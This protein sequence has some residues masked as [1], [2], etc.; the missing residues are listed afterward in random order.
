MARGPGGHHPT[1]TKPGLALLTAA[2]TTVVMLLVVG[3][4]W[5]AFK[6][7]DGLGRTELHEECRTDP[8]LS[9]LQGYCVVVSRHP[10]TPAH[11]ERTYL[12]ITQVWDG[13]EV[14]V[15]FRAQYP[16]HVGDAGT[17]LD[18]DWSRPDE[19][20]VVADPETGSAISY[21]FDQYGSIR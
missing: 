4:L 15:R 19:R 6:I 21:T 11:S 1:V 7:V 5:G 17:E 8:T 18:V 14:D 13:A 20:I 2:V 10:A 9:G 3:V 16:F 12:E